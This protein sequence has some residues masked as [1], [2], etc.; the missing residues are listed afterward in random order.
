MPMISLVVVRTNQNPVM[1]S[2][3]CMEE[4]SKGYSVGCSEEYLEGCSEGFPGGC[5]E[6]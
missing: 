3:S 4:Y 6:G 2:E 5:S 1:C